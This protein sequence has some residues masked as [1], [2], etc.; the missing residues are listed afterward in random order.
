MYVISKFLSKKKCKNDCCLHIKPNVS[1]LYLSKKCN[2]NKYF[3][4]KTTVEQNVSGLK[5]QLLAPNHQT[6]IEVV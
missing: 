6:D 5:T 4:L 2:I 3:S 1:E